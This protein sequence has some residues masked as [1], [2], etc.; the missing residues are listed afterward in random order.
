MRALTRPIRWSL[1]C[2]RA[3][4]FSTGFWSYGHVSQCNG[5]LS[6]I[7][8]IFFDVPI[9]FKGV[10]QSLVC[11]LISHLLSWLLPHTGLFR[12]IITG[13]TINQVN[14]GLFGDILEE[15]MERRAHLQMGGRRHE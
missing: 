14:N 1:E 15:M 2:G 5:V 3:F 7:G 13:G 10:V 4:V 11:S 8:R 9:D 6:Y 12:R